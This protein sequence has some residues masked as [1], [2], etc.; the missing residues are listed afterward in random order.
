MR[1]VLGSRGREPCC[2][3]HVRA[4][5]K[6]EDYHLVEYLRAAGFTSLGREPN[7][8]EF[9]RR[10]YLNELKKLSVVLSESGCVGACVRVVVLVVEIRGGGRLL[11][12]VWF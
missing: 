7:K 3:S 10:L 5:W 11:G 1:R 4:C 6:K 9:Q 8:L 2:I 12:I